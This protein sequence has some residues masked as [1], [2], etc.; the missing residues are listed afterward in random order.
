MIGEA[1]ATVSGGTPPYISTVWDNGMTGASI[2]GLGF[3]TYVVTATDTNGCTAIDTVQVDSILTRLGRI[4]FLTNLKIFPNPTSGNLTI[5]LEL[6]EAKDINIV[7]Y[8]MAGQLIKDFGHEY[9]AKTQIRTDL[10][11]FPSGV[12]LVRIVLD[13]QV[14]TKRLIVSKR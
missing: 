7:I 4:N 13:N 6:S 10:S 5:D 9:T 8:D 1:M 12:Y 3:G 2:S 14:I 11:I